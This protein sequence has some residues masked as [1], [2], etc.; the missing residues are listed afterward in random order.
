MPIEVMLPKLDAS[1]TWTAERR[2]VNYRGGSVDAE[3]GGCTEGLVGDRDAR[4]LDRSRQN[5]SCTKPDS[6]WCLMERRTRKIPSAL[7]MA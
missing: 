3:E 7:P 2:Q 5:G 4:K 6:E 1:D